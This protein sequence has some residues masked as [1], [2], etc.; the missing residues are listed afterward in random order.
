MRRKP[1]RISE[2]DLWIPILRLLDASPNG[3]M[4]TSDLIEGL[5]GMFQP[6][7]EDAEILAGRNDSRFSQIVRNI[8]SHRTSP[9]NL[10]AQGFADY[11]ESN[12]G[13]RITTKGEELL[14]QLGILP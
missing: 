11:D 12:H 8:V 3:F 9:S 4:A 5:E 10:I 7:G 13:L 6:Q 2:Q 1:N 14:R